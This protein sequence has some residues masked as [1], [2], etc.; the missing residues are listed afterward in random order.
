MYRFG[1]VSR[2]AASLVCV[3]ALLVTCFAQALSQQSAQGKRPLTHQDYDSWH[4]IQSPQISRDGKFVAYAYMAQDADSEIVAR[5]VATGAEWRA[6]RGY[7]PPLPPPDESTP[8]VAEVI[9]AQARLV[10]PAFTADS[11]FVVFSIEPTK[12]ELNKAKKDKKKP[13]DMPKNALGIMDVSSGQVARIDRVKNF[14][15]PEDGS[16]FIACLLEAKPAS[17]SAD[18]SRAAPNERSTI[19]TAGSSTSQA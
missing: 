5:N 16:G 14:Q 11:H 3:I 1:K 19:P 9:A 6:P 7:H 10:R 4:S 12:A 2:Q 17:G 18:G 15:V 8:N 13:E